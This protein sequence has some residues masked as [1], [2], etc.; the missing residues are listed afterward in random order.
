VTK[1]AGGTIGFVPEQGTLTYAD[2]AA[3]PDDGL[4]HELL[5]GELV[6]TPA[7]RTR[8]Q[9]VAFELTVALR[10]H[11]KRR[12]LGQVFIGPVDVIFTERDVLEPD[13]VFVGSEQ[14]EI[15]T[16]LNIRGVP[17]LL[18]E[19]VSDS[20][21]DRVRKRDVYERCGV[22]EYWVADPDAD[23][24]EVDRLRAGRYGKPEIVGTEDTLTT[25]AI[26]GLELDV[27][28]IFARP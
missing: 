5:D 24:I 1:R 26:P 9:T 13:V 23:R 3:L 15:I 6:V 18:I 17:E 11:V 19:V 10:D 16:E 7:P 12:R 25:A 27:A 4:R 28:T 2:L 14:T 22:P 20:R 21:M 8:H